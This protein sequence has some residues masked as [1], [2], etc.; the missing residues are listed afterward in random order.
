MK[1]KF[2]NKINYAHLAQQNNR[3]NNENEVYFKKNQQINVFSTVEFKSNGF[4]QDQ[5]LQSDSNAPRTA[6]GN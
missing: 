2:I 1:S 6:Y 5:N 3:K 4:N